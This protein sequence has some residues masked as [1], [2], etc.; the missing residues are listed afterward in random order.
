MHSNPAIH[1]LIDA[2]VA[3]IN[4][5]FRRP[6]SSEA[7]FTKLCKVAPLDSGKNA[8]TF[9]YQSSNTEKLENDY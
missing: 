2:H 1:D 9:H 6:F 8:I 3:Y 5:N 4:C 7:F